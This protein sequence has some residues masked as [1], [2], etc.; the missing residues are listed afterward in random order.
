MLSN[1]NNLPDENWNNLCAN[2]LRDWHGI[3]TRYSPQGEVI[4]SF[5][6]LRRFQ[7]NP[8]QTE[9]AQNNRYMYTDAKTDE[10]SWQYNQQSNSLPDGLFHPQ[11]P[12]MR[13][14]FFECGAATW[15]TTKL[16]TSSYFVVELFFKY[17][18]LRNSVALVYEESGILKRTASIR[19]DSTNFPS[20]YWSSEINLTTE[21][22]LSGNWQGTSV[23]MTPDLKISPAV[24]SQL[25]WPIEGNTTFFYPDGISLSCPMQVSVGTPFTIVGN[26]LVTPSE[27]QQVSVKYDESGAFSSVTR[28][29]FNLEA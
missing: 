26:W 2:H 25:H 8:E 7:S 13:G 1:F 18:D 3:W 29:L 6:S 11:S 23:T 5:K 17:Q 21:R 28:D 12:L 14:F 20:N 27:L 19:E 15:T 9:I 4:E 22:N 16:E 10:F 24:P